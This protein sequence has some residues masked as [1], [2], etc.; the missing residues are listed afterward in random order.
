MISGGRLYALAF[1]P[2]VGVDED[3]ATGSACVGLAA[4][5][6]L[7]HPEAGRDHALHIEQGVHM[8]RPSQIEAT[9]H[10]GHGGLPAVTLAG[11]T[12]VLG[13]RVHRR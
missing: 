11:H 8:G 13:Q 7:S 4:H 9:A 10:T 2:A 3:P 1:V 5:A 6:A 12:T